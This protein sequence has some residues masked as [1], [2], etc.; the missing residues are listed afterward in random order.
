[1]KPLSNRSIPS[2]QTRA[3]YSPENEEDVAAIVAD[4]HQSGRRLRV[5]GSALSPNGASFSGGW[6][7]VSWWWV[8]G[9]MSEWDTRVVYAVWR[10]K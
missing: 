2:N 5:V 6:L 3:Y 1:M 8:G 4:C 7:G 10:L 9:W